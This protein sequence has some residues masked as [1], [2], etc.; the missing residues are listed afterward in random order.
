AKNSSKWTSNR[1]NSTTSCN[2]RVSQFG[3]QDTLGGLAEGGAGLIAGPFQWPFSYYRLCRWWL[4]F[5]D[6]MPE[7]KELYTTSGRHSPDVLEEDPN[8]GIALL[9]R[10]NRLDGLLSPQP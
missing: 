1:R 4:V 6:A 8:L 9:E 5:L 3:T 10:A 2:D 7:P